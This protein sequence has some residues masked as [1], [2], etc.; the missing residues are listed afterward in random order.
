M[1]HDRIIFRLY[2]TLINLS[3]TT[4][5]E[6]DKQKKRRRENEALKLLSLL[7]SNVVGRAMSS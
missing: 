7:L 3:P 2:T 6:K 4:Y 5:R 1:M